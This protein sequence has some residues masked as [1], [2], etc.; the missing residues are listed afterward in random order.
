MLDCQSLV[1]NLKKG[2]KLINT[3]YMNI[4]SFACAW[5]DGRHCKI[6]VATK[7]WRSKGK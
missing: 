5:N 3:T 7:I 6:R 1:T 4:K 2:I